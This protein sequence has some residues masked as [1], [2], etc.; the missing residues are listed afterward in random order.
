MISVE[1]L[2]STKKI[3]TI[4]TIVSKFIEKPKISSLL[5]S[6]LKFIKSKALLKKSFFLSMLLDI[7]LLK[8]R[9]SS[10]NNLFED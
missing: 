6:V 5:F 3:T 4:I 7:S 9:L 1:L 2:L 8:E 10:E